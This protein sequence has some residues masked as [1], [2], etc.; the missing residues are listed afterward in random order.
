MVALSLC[1][2][3]AFADGDSTADIT[4]KGSIKVPPCTINQVPNVN[5][6]TDIEMTKFKGAGSQ[7]DPVPFQVSMTCPAGIKALSYKLTPAGGSQPVSDG[8][9]GEMTL[10]GSSTASGVAVK[11]MDGDGSNHD[12]IPLG[13]NNPVGDRYDP[14]KFDQTVKLNYLADYVQTADNV[15]GGEADAQAQFTLSYE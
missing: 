15:K 2:T 4:F 5:L 12:P 11:I 9:D 13:Q 6:G 14:S 1:A 8:K 7:S 10:S 3:H